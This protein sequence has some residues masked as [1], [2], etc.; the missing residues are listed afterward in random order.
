MVVIKVRV[1]V[2]VVVPV[3]HA[4]HLMGGKRVPVPVVFAVPVVIVVV[5]RDWGVILHVNVNL[6][7]VL[8]AFVV[9][10]VLSMMLVLPEVVLVG[11]DQ[12]CTKQQSKRDSSNGNTDLHD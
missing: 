10:C 9:G 7:L 12:R 2:F 5:V 4:H 3:C 11:D 6:D 8:L 1:T